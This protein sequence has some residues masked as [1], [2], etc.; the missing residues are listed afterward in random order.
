MFTLKEVREAKDQ[1]HFLT[2][3][4]LSGKIYDFAITKYGVFVK[5]GKDGVL[6]ELK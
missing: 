6:E 4:V 3:K 2:E 1:I 5:M